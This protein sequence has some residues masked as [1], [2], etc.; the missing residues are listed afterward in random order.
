[1]AKDGSLKLEN[2]DNYADMITGK[3]GAV[4]L[5]SCLDERYELV[6]TPTAKAA[7][8]LFHRQIS[9]C[10]LYMPERAVSTSFDYT[11]PVRPTVQSYI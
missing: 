11:V 10:I 8:F 1:M 7:G 9:A 4:V 3:R 5:R 2:S 6:D